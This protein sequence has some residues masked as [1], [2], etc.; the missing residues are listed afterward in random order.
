MLH[1]REES[2]LSLDE[3][4]L[5]PM[6]CL[7]PVRSTLAGDDPAADGQHVSDKGRFRPQAL[8]I[9]G[10][11]GRGDTGSPALVTN[12]TVRVPQRP[13]PLPLFM[14]CCCCC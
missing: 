11:G 8:H 6:P 3:L 2:S 5:R 10:P 14:L 13:P 1:A 7:S 9:P 4:A 12:P